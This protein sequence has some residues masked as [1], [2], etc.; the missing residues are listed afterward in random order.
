MSFNVLIVDDSNSMRSVVKKILTI[1]GFRMD[2]CYE[3]GNGLQALDILSSS[4]V[5]IVLSDL[6]MPVMNGLEMLAA[7]KKDDLM[8][9]IPVVIISTE[10]SEERMKVAFEMGAKHFIKKP[11]TPEHVRNILYEV[12]GFGGEVDEKSERNDDDGDF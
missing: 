1:S 4:W 9:N 6:N 12:V 7:M 10:S 3:A 2:Q 8:R 5:D 11:F